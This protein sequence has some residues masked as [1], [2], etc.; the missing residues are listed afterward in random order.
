MQKR[1]A[2]SMH[3]GAQH[4]ALHIVLPTLLIRRR[5]RAGF[6]AFDSKVGVAVPNR[7]LWAT[8]PPRVTQIRRQA[9]TVILIVCSLADCQL[10]PHE[11]KKSSPCGPYFFGMYHLLAVVRISKA[12]H[13]SRKGQITSQ[14]GPSQI[15]RR[16]PTETFSLTKP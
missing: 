11:K 6:I 3:E 1:A 14:Q 2:R 10:L 13:S 8:A 15:C 16:F 7:V 9:I 5:A 4:K 12:S